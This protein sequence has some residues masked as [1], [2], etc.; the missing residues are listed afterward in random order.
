MA[1]DNVAKIRLELDINSVLKQVKVIQDRLNAISVVNIKNKFGTQVFDGITKGVKKAESSLNGVAQQATKATEKVITL[2][3]ALRQAER[4]YSKAY[5]AHNTDIRWQETKEAQ[6]LVE[7]IYKAKQALIDFRNLKKTID[8]QITGKQASKVQQKAYERQQKEYLRKEREKERE[9]SKSPSQIINEQ[10]QIAFRNF[11]QQHFYAGSTMQKMDVE[12]INNWKKSKREFEDLLGEKTL[13]KEITELTNDLQ[14]KVRNNPNFVGSDEYKQQIEDIRRI[15]ALYN[16]VKGDI[17]GATEKVKEQTKAVRQN[18]N[19]FVNYTREL[20][21]IEQ[22]ASKVFHA[23]ASDNL[24]DRQIKK[25]TD[26][27]NVLTAQYKKI[28][29]ESV[30]FRKKVGISN[31]RGFYDLNSTY[32]YFLAKFRS[33]VTAGIA[34]QVETFAINAIPN[35]VNTMSTYQQNRTNFAQVLPNELGDNQKFM[36]KVMSDFT[37][38]ASDYGASVQ[39]VVEAGRLWGRQYK[40]VATVQALVRNS[41]KLSITDNMS[42]TEV[43]KGLEATMQ[44]YNIHLKDANEAQQVSGH[45][46]DSWAK[47]ADNAVVTASD[48]AKANEQS[49][50]SA[51]EAGIGF[52]YLNAMIATMSGA[53]GKAGAEIGRSI[54]SMLVSMKSAK[55]QKY[56]RDLGIA[57]TE[58]GTDGVMHVRSYEKVIT[59]LM[60]K[61]KTSP[62]DVSNVVLAMSGGKYQ[63]NNVMAFL[64]SYDAMQKKLNTV[65]TSKGWADS[66]VQQQYNTISRQMQALEADVQQ[67]VISLDEAGASNGIS[68]LIQGFRELLRFLKELDP[69]TIKTIGQ[70]ITLSV[71]LKALSGGVNSITAIIGNTVTSLNTMGNVLKTGVNSGLVR[72]GVS[73]TTLATGALSLA[74]NVTALISILIALAG[75]WDAVYTAQ[76]KDY[77]QREKEKEID[78]QIKAYEDYLKVLD[79]L[80]RENELDANSNAKSAEAKDKLREASNNLR[81]AIGDEAYVRIMSSKDVQSAIKAE[82]SVLLQSAKICAEDKLNRIDT[83]IQITTVQAEQ[84]RERIRLMQAELQATKEAMQKKLAM[85]NAVIG[86][87]L[88]KQPWIVRKFLANR[89]GISEELGNIDDLN[90]SLSMAQDRLSEIDSQLASYNEERKKYQSDVDSINGKVGGITDD[91]SPS[92]GGIDKYGGGA[93]ALQEKIKA[94]ALLK[95]RNKLLYE[96]KLLQTAYNDALKETEWKERWNGDSLSASK[97]KIALYTQ[98]QKELEEQEKKFAD[99][100]KEMIDSLDK[101]MEKHKNIAELLDYKTDLNTDEKLKNIEINK[102]VYGQIEAYRNIIS[103]IQTINQKIQETKGLQQEL[104]RTITENTMLSTNPADVANRNIESIKRESNIEQYDASSRLWFDDIEKRKIKIQELSKVLNEQQK[105]LEKYQANWNNANNNTTTS[106]SKL[107]EIKVKL[108]K[109]KEAVA[110][111]NSELIKLQRD[112]DA[113]VLEQVKSTLSSQFSTMILQGQSFS[114]TMKNIWKNLSSYIVQRLFEV[115]VMENL[116]NGIFPKSHTGEDVSKG[117]PTTHHIGASVASYPKM[118][119]GGMVEQ[120]RL[121]VVPK[122]KSDEVIRT[123]QVGEEVNSVADRRSNEILATVAMK[124]IDSKN[125]RPTNINI[126]AIDSKSFAEYLNDNA[127]VLM[128]VLNKQGALGRG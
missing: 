97:E 60:Q 36:N 41:T 10:R 55:A 46:V 66:Q 2:E 33:K 40:E 8:E 73:M 59:E 94:N 49:A 102:E 7:N 81:K 1:I 61:L 31:S 6:K 126:M 85:A 14:A 44:Q 108:E 57:T 84:T 62:K 48:L 56:F 16:Q 125:E 77:F 21:K 28:N 118:H 51:Y 9:Y 4:E 34:E 119:T 91:S 63:Y 113:K 101:E 87:D 53:T 95:E 122:L 76:N 123:L 3:S 89:F 29:K 86:G 22:R 105:L 65:N 30:E 43:N 69:A 107:Y 38:I 79:K 39:D 110:Q 116:L 74:G 71:T 75:A 121:G 99:F 103:C 100:R 12:W 52:N 37:K 111:T 114:D 93:N 54:R 70:L 127:D 42:L 115:Y 11:R 88:N 47:L 104:N 25:L 20:A 83:Q 19:E 124:A 72:T 112:E 13:K 78:N 106:E 23:L 17:S 45:I 120:G 35:F 26:D 96:A 90:K 80:K 32:D 67:L 64:K 18:S 27:L 117:K 15:R 82:L 58:L 68:S 5:Y 109:Q 24:N 50:G 98:R 92:G 128:A